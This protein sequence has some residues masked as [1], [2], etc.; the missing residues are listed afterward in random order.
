MCVCGQRLPMA[1]QE[2]HWPQIQSDTKQIDCNHGY[3]KVRVQLSS[4]TSP[5][6]IPAAF[7]QPVRKLSYLIDFASTLPIFRPALSKAARPCANAI[8]SP[9]DI[10][11]AKS[12]FQVLATMSCIWHRGWL[13][14][15]R[16]SAPS[17]LSAAARPT[18][19]TSPPRLRKYQAARRIFSPNS[20][21]G[22]TR[23][24]STV[25]VHPAE[26]SVLSTAVP[27]RST[28][29]PCRRPTI[30]TRPA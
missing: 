11:V 27:T 7:V 13:V 26:Q 17:R 29:R 8:S 2:N 23:S 14:R 30:P 16:T 12:H 20:P 3:A 6:D 22:P 19:V 9:G 10:G 25:P 4:E 15:F 18:T 24:T 28:E 5:Y 1:N 21:T